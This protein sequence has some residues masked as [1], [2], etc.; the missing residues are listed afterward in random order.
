MQNWVELDDFS[1][2]KRKR[3]IT[4]TNKEG[5]KSFWEKQNAQAVVHNLRKHPP[6]ENR[7]LYNSTFLTE[8]SKSSKKHTSFRCYLRT[9]FFTG[10]GTV[11]LRGHPSHAKI[12]LSA[13]QRK[14]TFISQLFYDPEWW[15]EPGVQTDILTPC[16]QALY[17]MS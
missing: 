8:E 13:G 9:L 4:L 7:R 5:G 3:H 15:S 16:S 10:D 17:R 1:K 14:Y 12:W 11:T 2:K 6:I